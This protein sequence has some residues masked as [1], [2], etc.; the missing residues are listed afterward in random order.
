MVVKVANICELNQTPKIEYPLFWSY[1]VITDGD[2]RDKILDII[3]E[4]DHKISFSKHSKGGKY[5]S[6]EVVVFV[7]SD[8]ERVLIFENLKRIAKFV[9]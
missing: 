5:L 1:R 2:L 6:F 3:K 9:L 4:Y 7:K 8:N